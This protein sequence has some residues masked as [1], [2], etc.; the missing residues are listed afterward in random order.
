[1][2]HQHISTYR[3]VLKD[4]KGTRFATSEETAYP[5]ALAAEI[6]ACFALELMSS[7]WEPPAEIHSTDQIASLVKCCASTGI[8]PK[9]SKLPPLVREH[10][11]V[12]VIQGPH[13]SFHQFR[14]NPMERTKKPL[15]IPSD[16][17][18][19]SNSDVTTI[20]ADAQLLRFK[21]HGIFN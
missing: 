11:A 9:S 6:A 12:L 19:S 5:Y 8:Q 20:P 15:S 1:M 21:Q 14:V 18:V 16:C 3:G 13:S 7:G 17:I 4:S 2:S 10:K